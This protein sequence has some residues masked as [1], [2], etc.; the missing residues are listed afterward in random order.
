MIPFRPMTDTEPSLTCSPLLRATLLIFDYIETNGPIGLTAGK[1]LK[2]YFVEWAAKAFDWP[3]YS[4]EYLYAV[5]KVLNE[6]DYLP[7][8][9]LHDLLVS[10]KLTRHYQGTMH[11]TKLARDLKT[12]PAA[13]WT[14][15]TQRFLIE[16]DHSRYTRHGDRLVGDW[17][18]FLGII[19]VEAETA[20]TEERLCS[21]LFGGSEAEIRRYDYHLT[22]TFYIHVL[23]PLCW[24]GLLE[25]HRVGK[26]MERR[27]F[28]TK[29]PLWH[30]A[31]ALGSD[32]EPKMPT[33]H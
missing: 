7:L 22:A 24:M 15:L 12:R 3:H 17:D 20:V 16:T 26:G 29:T 10:A 14:H 23:R 9:L 11:L 13:L 4:L 31:L 21:V 1:A 19:N 5:N 18:I 33:L 6:V 32:E 8:V 25:E 2:R 27:E 28:F 30:A